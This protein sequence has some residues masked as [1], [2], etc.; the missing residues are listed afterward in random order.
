MEWIDDLRKHFFVHKAEDLNIEAAIE[1]K[2]ENIPSSLF[3]YRAVNDYSIN[4]LLQDTVWCTSASN[5]NDPY[6][7][8]L[9]FDLSG[10]FINDSF[11]ESMDNELKKEGED[12]IG[13][14]DKN[15]ILNSADPIESM[16]RL[17]A[18]KTG[19]EVPSE[20]EDRLCNVLKGVIQ[21]NFVEMNER[22]NAAAKEGYKICSFSERLDS[23]L[24]WSHYSENHTGF[25]MEYDF[26]ELPIEDIRSRCLWPVLYDDELFD[27]SRFF[28]EQKNTGSF[29][30]LFGIISSIHKARDWNYEH[31]WRLIIPLGP[32]DPSMNYNVPKPKAIYLG[33]KI[34][35]KDKAA[36]INIARKK[37][38]DVY[39]M[40]LSHNRFEMVPNEID[41]KIEESHNKSLQRNANASVE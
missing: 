20:M 23:M 29:N 38:I 8:S 12:G 34:T 32:K 2:K 13:N 19:T 3:K 41:I 35:D 27:A 39:Q 17:A 28:K 31:E 10:D 18:K 24:M 30:N 40:N 5:F 15:S 9:C 1:I 21:K 7:S 26:K 4:N 37:Q 6:D 11:F 33:A 22:F 25:V 14:I 16:I 36:L